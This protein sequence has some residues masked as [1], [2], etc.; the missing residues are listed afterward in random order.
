MVG[1]TPAGKLPPPTLEQ[2]AE[3][4]LPVMATVLKNMAEAH[5]HV[6]RDMERLAEL[7]ELLPPEAES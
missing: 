3:L 2:R 7:V 5:R 6:A 1:F 4:A